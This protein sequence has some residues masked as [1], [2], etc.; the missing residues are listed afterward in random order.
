MFYVIFSTILWWLI[1]NSSGNLYSFRMKRTEESNRLK[2]KSIF[3]PSNS[4]SQHKKKRER[5]FV[6]SRI[7][8]SFSRLYLWPLVQVYCLGHLYLT[9]LISGAVSDNSRELRKST[10]LGYGRI[11]AKVS[12]W[13]VSPA[14]DTHH[15]RG[16]NEG[17][18]SH[19]WFY[20]QPFHPEGMILYAYT[21]YL[22]FFQN[23]REVGFSVPSQNIFLGTRVHIWPIDLIRSIV[24]RNFILMLKLFYNY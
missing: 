11:L 13:S 4:F 8:V 2:N 24:E 15:V 1:L 19:L 14:F 20:T 9:A 23:E 7:Y 12:F 16:K 10:G 21:S 17:A 18:T 22:F 5:W 3:T 6:E